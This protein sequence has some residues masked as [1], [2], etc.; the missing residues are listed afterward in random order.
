MDNQSNNSYNSQTNGMLDQKEQGMRDRKTIL[1]LAALL[2]FVGATAFAVFTGL[3]QQ[4]EL[5]NQKAEVEKYQKQVTELNKKFEDYTNSLA[6]FDEEKAIKA[7][8]YHSIF[9]TNG[10]VYHAQITAAN[11]EYFVI[12]N[13][14]YMKNDASTVSLVK[15]GCEV[16]GPKDQMNIPR[17]Q[18]TFWEGL[19]DDGQVVKAIE[20]YKKQNPD[21]QKC[22]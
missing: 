19:K 1:K 8:Q 11:K 15:L 12:E 9:L 16:H 10:Q 6:D 2:V 21:G 13:I 20:E 22:S 4:S 18:V 3:N 5:N 7:S 14:Y 17:A